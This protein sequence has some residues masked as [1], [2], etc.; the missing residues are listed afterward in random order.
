MSREIN[1]RP[2]L[3]G[4]VCRVGCQEIVFPSRS[5]MLGE[6]D[7]YFANP[8]KV[9]AEYLK[10]AVNPLDPGPVPECAVPP[11]E[12]YPLAATERR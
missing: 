3:N 8:G 4:Y 1:I 7:R 6:I 5:Q 10:N 11:R 2:A 9:E 12:P